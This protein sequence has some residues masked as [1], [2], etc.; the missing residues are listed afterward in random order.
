[1]KRLGFAGF[2]FSLTITSVQAADIQGLWK[3]LDGQGRVV[4]D[5]AIGVSNGRIHGSA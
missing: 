5:W 4:A 1:M 3:Y 2:L